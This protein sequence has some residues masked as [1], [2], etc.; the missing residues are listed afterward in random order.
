MTSYKLCR[1]VSASDKLYRMLA[2]NW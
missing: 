2:T 1:A